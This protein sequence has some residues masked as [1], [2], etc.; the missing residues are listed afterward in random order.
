MYKLIS[1]CRNYSEMKKGDCFWTTV[2][3]FTSAEISLKRKILCVCRLYKVLAFGRP[4][5]PKKVWPGS[6]DPFQNFT[7]P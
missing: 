6:R 3:N 2:Y 1:I 7:P 4:T 5:I